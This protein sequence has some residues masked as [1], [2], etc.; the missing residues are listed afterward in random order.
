MEGSQGLA[1][2]YQYAAE[3]Q[4][5]HFDRLFSELHAALPPEERW[6]AS[7]LRAQIRLYATDPT[8]A[9]DLEQIGPPVGSPRFSPLSTQ[10]KLGTPNRFIVFP[11]TPG[12][13]QRFV[14]AL[15]RMREIFARWYGE[16]G[17]I[18]LRQFQGEVHYFMGDVQAALAL[19]EEQSR[20]AFQNQTDAM[21]ALILQFRCYLA[22][23]QPQ[24]AEACMLDIIRLSK[25]HPECVAAYES[26]RGWAGATTSWSGD[27]PRFLDGPAGKHAPILDDRLAY[28]HDGSSQATALENPFI[29]YA[30]RSYEDAYT[31]RESY[32]DLFHAMHWLVIG[33]RRQAEVYFLKA[34]EIA[35]ASGVIMP[36]VESGA[37]ATPLLRYIKNSRV[38]CSHQWLD[39]ILA[40]VEAYETCIN[41]YRESY[42]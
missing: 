15:P 7:I 10:W 39:D 37:Q 23:G 19:A 32:M 26:F 9:D 22:S 18:L 20:A 11:K 41:L 34:Y 21:E 16:Q 6:E 40:R 36:I 8:V 38:D 4:L 17:N 1:L 5:S 13:L 24:K 31:L 42:T 3:Y 14:Q 25:A 27:S 28:I 30:K 33:D 12:T 2:L 35:R 29:E